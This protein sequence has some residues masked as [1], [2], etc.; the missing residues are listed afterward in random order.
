[1]DAGNTARFP[2]QNSNARKNGNHPSFPSGVSVF[3][4]QKSSQRNIEALS[5]SRGLP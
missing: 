2:Q 1:M 4:D 5:T 3:E